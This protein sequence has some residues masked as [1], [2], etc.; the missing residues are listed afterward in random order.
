MNQTGNTQH[1]ERGRAGAEWKPCLSPCLGF[2]VPCS[3]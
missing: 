3:F 2:G 1:S